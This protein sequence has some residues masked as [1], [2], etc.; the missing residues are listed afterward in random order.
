MIPPSSRRASRSDTPGPGRV[1]RVL[2]VHQPWA[3][4]LCLGWKPVENRTWQTP[5]RGRIYIHATRLESRPHPDRLAAHP[6]QVVS[7]ILGHWNRP[8]PR[9][10]GAI[11]GSVDLVDIVP[12][13]WVGEIDR[14]IRA[15]TPSHLFLPALAQ[16]WVHAG[17]TLERLARL[18]QQVRPLSER[19]PGHV[20]SLFLGPEC[21]LVEQP[22]LL[23]RPIMTKG[24]LNLWRFELPPQ[25]E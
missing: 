7:E 23:S 8:G 4:G 19:G 25:A 15:G 12:L 3:D 20:F 16:R 14:Q 9:Q 2:S 10:T 6:P 5:Y 18:E 1:V 17:A 11:L 24:K 22:R 21:W 13:G